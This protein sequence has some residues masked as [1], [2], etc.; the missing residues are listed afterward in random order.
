M[1][2]EKEAEDDP[3]DEDEVERELEDDELNDNEAGM[4]EGFDRDEAESFDKDSKK[5]KKD[6]N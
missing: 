2:E 5:K 4:L 3:Y 6:K 1:T